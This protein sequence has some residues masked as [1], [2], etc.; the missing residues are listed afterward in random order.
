V[1]IKFS[2]TSY[3][4][5]PGTKGVYDG[6]DMNF[7][8]TGRENG[9]TY[10]YSIFAQDAAQNWSAPVYVECTPTGVLDARAIQWDAYR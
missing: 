9:V 10:Y 2:K 5:A 1:R 8:H 7:T 6:S 3:V 4:N